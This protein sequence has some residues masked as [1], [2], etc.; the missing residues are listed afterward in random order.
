MNY[1][2]YIRKIKAETIR[3]KGRNISTNIN[4]YLSIKYNI[5]KDFNTLFYRD[6]NTYNSPT[7]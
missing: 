6:F 2:Y 7:Y 4:P 5:D 1:N 3:D